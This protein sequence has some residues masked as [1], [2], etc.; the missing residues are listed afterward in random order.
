MFT[1]LFRMLVIIRHHLFDY[2]PPY[3]AD[4]RWFYDAGEVVDEAQVAESYDVQESNEYFESDEDYE[5]YDDYMR[6]LAEEAEAEEADRFELELLASE[7]A[8]DENWRY[9]HMGTDPL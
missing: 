7:Y 8:P 4:Y 1:A 9:D 6:R 3:N 2:Y 5:D